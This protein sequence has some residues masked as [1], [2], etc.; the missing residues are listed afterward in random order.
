MSRM[1]DTGVRYSN[2]HTTALCSPTRASLMTGRNALYG[3]LGGESSCWYPDLIHDNHPM[4]PP[5][6]RPPRCDR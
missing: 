4:A 3:F 6:T 5:A 1:A 2:F